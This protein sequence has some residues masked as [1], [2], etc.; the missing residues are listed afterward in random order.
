MQICIIDWEEW[1]AACLKHTAN[2]SNRCTGLQWTRQTKTFSLGTSSALLA[3]ISRSQ[4]F[5]CT[6]YIATT[7]RCTKT[8]LMQQC[9]E[10]IGSC[11]PHLAASSLLRTAT[12]ER[13]ESISALSSSL[14]SP[15]PCALQA[16]SHP[17]CALAMSIS[18]L[19]SY[20]WKNKRQRFSRYTLVP[21]VYILSF[22][23][24]SR[25][26]AILCCLVSLLSCHSVQSVHMP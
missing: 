26:D 14:L 1:L 3:C 15:S 12:S 21:L 17:E 22:K 10:C 9:P 11:D 16:A 13:R 25:K 20:L 4:R 8:K 19:Y 6:S 2:Y 5:Y 7:M 18:Y 24:S 23:T